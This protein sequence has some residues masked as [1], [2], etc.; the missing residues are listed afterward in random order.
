[1]GRKGI[2]GVFDNL[3]INSHEV[4]ILPVNRTLVCLKTE[5]L[6]GYL[7]KRLSISNTED[8]FR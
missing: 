8:L 1:M 7:L 6:Q 5:D 4:Y 3:R 2:E